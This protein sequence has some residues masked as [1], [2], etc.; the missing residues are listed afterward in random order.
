M[1]VALS[2]IDKDRFGVVT[3]KVSI[4]KGESIHGLIDWCAMR[5]VELLIARCDTSEI[6]LVHAMEEAGFQLMDTLVYFL[7]K[8]ISVH[9]VILPDD[10]SWRIASEQDA[11]LVECCAQM[12]FKNYSGHYHADPKLSTVDSD[13]VYS[14]WARA[15]CL[16]QPVA[17]AVLLICKDD[18]VVAFLTLK[19]LNSKSAEIVLNGVHPEYQA[20]G[21]Y[22][23]LVRL[24]K[25]WC[26]ENE[27]SQLLVSTQITNTAP[28]KVWCRQ[29]FEPRNSIYTFH[30]WF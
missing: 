25:N 11:D 29:G 2:S 16:S 20:H 15:S 21:L 9:P 6:E 23:S 26:S 3:A 13:L 27:I 28:Q 22:T 8:A 18:Q 10:Y 5:A 1:K 7:Q 19:K 24:A 4:E 14:S 12:A 30:K 17:D